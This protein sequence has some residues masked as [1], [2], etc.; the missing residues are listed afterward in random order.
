M[1]ERGGGM[2][3]SN[4]EFILDEISIGDPIIIEGVIIGEIVA[5]GDR[6]GVHVER[7]GA[8][9]TWYYPREE[10]KK[11]TCFSVG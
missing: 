7:Y 3:E 4:S 5:I 9:V 8:I 1:K 2:V 10:L 6:I 11:I